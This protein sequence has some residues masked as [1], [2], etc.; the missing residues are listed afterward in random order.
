[1]NEIVWP[2]IKRLA[3]EATLALA[4]NHKVVIYDGAVLIESGWT[5]LCHELWVTIIPP[6]EV[7]MTD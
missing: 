3:S 4:D 2:E 5:S 7:S 1:M 6:T